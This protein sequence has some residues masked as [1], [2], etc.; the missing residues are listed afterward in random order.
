[1]RIWVSLR[2]KDSV[3]FRLVVCLS[4]FNLKHSK[5]FAQLIR[6]TWRV[7][8]LEELCPIRSD[9]KSSL[10]YICKIVAPPFCFYNDG[11]SC[12]TFAVLTSWHQSAWQQSSAQAEKSTW[13]NNGCK[14][15][16]T[17]RAMGKPRQLLGS[18][19]VPDKLHFPVFA[20]LRLS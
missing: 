15:K 14:I 6:L 12:Q 7:Q 19:Q 17:D 20:F 13:V 1:M 11:P 9:T 16:Q 10:R 5:R 4:L 3:I 2:E 18:P 8:L